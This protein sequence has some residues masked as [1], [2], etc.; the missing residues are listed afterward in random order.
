MSVMLSPSCGSSD[1]SSVIRHNG[2]A[3]GG[4]S[5]TI[6]IIGSSLACYCKQSQVTVRRK[7]S[8][9]TYSIEKDELESLLEAKF[10][11]LLLKQPLVVCSCLVTLI[12]LLRSP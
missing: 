3:S 11:L 2:H 9:C 4:A 12:V 10:I 5:C 6:R 1:G 7:L 8:Q